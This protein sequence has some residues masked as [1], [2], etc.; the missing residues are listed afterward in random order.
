MPTAVPPYRLIRSDRRTLSLEVTALPETVVRAPRRCSVAEIERFV[1]SH[2]R[3]I[4]RQTQRQL[5]RRDKGLDRP[6]DPQQEQCLRRQAAQVLP[7]RVAYYSTLMGLKPTG[8]RITSARKRFGSCSGKNSLC[9]S[10]RLMLY[11]AAAVDYVVVHEL[12]HIRHHDHSPSFYRLI[13]QYMP[14]YR[15]R[16]AMLKPHD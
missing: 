4:A 12:A 2:E 14:D 9:F 16:Q 13:E 6:V 15:Q 3:W 8:V 11:P 5:E 1:Q 7:E 10:W